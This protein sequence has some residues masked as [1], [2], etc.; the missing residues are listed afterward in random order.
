MYASWHRQRQNAIAR[1]YQPTVRIGNW[2]EAVILAQVLTIVKTDYSSFA[3]TALC[4]LAEHTAT[5][6]N[7]PRI[8]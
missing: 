3:V 5:H 8:T 4:A 2:M 7:H 1:T 6:D